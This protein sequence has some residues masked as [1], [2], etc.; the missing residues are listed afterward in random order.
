MRFR[1]TPRSMTSDDRLVLIFSD[2]RE[3]SQIWE[4][5]L[6]GKRQTNEDRPALSAT[7]L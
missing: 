4:L 7:A 2:F 1:L 5:G 3:I 6:A